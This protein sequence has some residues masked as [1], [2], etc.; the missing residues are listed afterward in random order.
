MNQCQVIDMWM[1]KQMESSASAK[2]QEH[3]QKSI[4]WT[5]GVSVD[6]LMSNIKRICNLLYNGNYMLGKKVFLDRPFIGGLG[7]N[8]HISCQY[9]K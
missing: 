7:K 8:I 5:I 3:V 6:L 9:I 1:K 4:H 2:K